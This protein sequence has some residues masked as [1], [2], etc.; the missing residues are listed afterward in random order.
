LKTT[1]IN[2]TKVRHHLHA[3]PETA[4]EEKKTASYITDWLQKLPGI[5]IVTNLGKTGVL[6][7]L[8]SG[9][10]GKSILFRAELDAL[11]IEEANN[12]SYS[13]I[14]PGKA[15]LCG[16]DG[17]M[18]ILLST[19]EK[20]SL[21][22]PP[23]GKI[24]F[25]FQPA[26]ET[27]Q[28]ALAVLDDSSFQDIKIDSVYALHNL[29]GFPLG[30]IVLRKGIFNACV[31]SMIIKLIGNTAHAA[32]PQYGINPALAISQILA[33]VNKFTQP[34]EHR[35][36]FALVVPIYA[37]LGEK[38]YGTSAGHGEVHF[39]LRTWTEERLDQLA[40]SLTKLIQDIANQESLKITIEWTECFT[41]IVNHDEELEIVKQAAQKNGL[42][43]LFKEYPFTWGEDFG[44]FTEK[45]GGAFFGIGAGQDRSS[46]HHP[47]YQFPDEL[48]ETGA[49]VFETIARLQ[50]NQSS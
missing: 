5:H 20:L 11:P 17:H 1:K 24:F 4:F 38:A 2:W 43:I 37:Q 10:K 32:Q 36:D 31:R 25:L 3:H 41:S 49:S 50:L 29:P 30:Q 44:H 40:Q 39:T 42:P 6:A 23:K 8:D 27:G 18:A 22:P 33:Q 9:V 28:G 19:A 45:Y 21:S 15:H 46:L 47:K 26:E 13:S 12:L 16:H 34:D 35:E 48:I 14:V 7:I